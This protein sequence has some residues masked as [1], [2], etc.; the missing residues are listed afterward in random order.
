MGGPWPPYALEMHAH[1]HCAEEVLPQA[2]W[3][4]LYGVFRFL[5]SVL[6]Q[7]GPNWFAHEATVA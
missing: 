1:A 5:R 6:A 3:S 4:L 2:G 7:H